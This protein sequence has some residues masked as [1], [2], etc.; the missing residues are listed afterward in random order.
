MSARN[1]F[2]SAL[3]SI[4]MLATVSTS[5]PAAP[6]GYVQTNLVSDVPGLAAVTDPNLRNPWGMSFSRTSPFWLSDQGTNVATLY[7]AAGVPQP[8]ASPLVVSVPGGPTGTVFNS[9]TGGFQ[10][11]GVASNF[12]FST[13]SGNIDAWNNAQGTAAAVMHTTAPGSY[14][15]LAIDGNQLYAANKATGHIDVFDS[16]FNPVTLGITAFAAPLANGLTPYGIQN[17]GGNLFVQY[18]G[19]RGAPGGFV[20]EFDASGNL[21]LS[22]VDS[23]LNAPWGAALAP[24]GFGQF[25]GD[26]LIGNFNDGMIN[27]FNPI[28]GAFLGTLSDPAGHPILNPGLWALQFRDTSAPNGNTGN[29]PNALFFSAGINSEADGLFGRITPNAVPEPATLQLLVMGL[30]AAMSMKLFARSRG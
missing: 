8:Q 13:L 6:I 3:V 22:I 30:F 27:A 19:P 18:S 5:L 17:I 12:I 29:D 10:I 21:L 25:G 4:G 16:S 14:T 15:G 20:A 1:R 23:H 11:N 26:L 28:S 7:N 2:P 9:S 24:A